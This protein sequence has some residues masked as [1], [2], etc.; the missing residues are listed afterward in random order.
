MLDSKGFDNWS[1]TYDQNVRET[2]ESG[3][4]PFAGYDAVLDEIARRLAAR[5]EKGNLLDIGFGTAVL[6]KRLYRAGYTV[7]GQ[8]FSPKMTALAREKMPGAKL[9]TGDFRTGLVPEL[10]AARYDAVIATYSLHHL[11]G[12]QK[13]DLLR[14]LL[15]LINKGGAL[16]IGDVA[17][18]TR[19]ELEACRAAEGDRWDPDEYY[20]VYDELRKEFPAL[21]FAPFSDC[22]GLLSLQK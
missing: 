18:R 17:F 15:P 22:A 3:R 4:Y 13:V 12:R 6:T 9:F 5:P 20:F 11:D 8:D 21:T 1:G 2:D 10:M 14:A 7:Y 16:Y 19:A